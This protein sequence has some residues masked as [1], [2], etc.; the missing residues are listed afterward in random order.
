MKLFIQCAFICLFGIGL[1]GVVAGDNTIA[2]IGLGGC[3]GLF[4]SLWAWGDDL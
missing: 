1:G 3:L 4:I 2:A